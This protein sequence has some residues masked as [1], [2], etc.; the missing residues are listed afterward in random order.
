MEQSNNISDLSIKKVVLNVLYKTYCDVHQIVNFKTFYDNK[1]SLFFNYYF[2]V[3]D[4]FKN[5]CEDN[6]IKNKQYFNLFNIAFANPNYEPSMESLK[7]SEFGYYDTNDAISEK[8]E[9]EESFAYQDSSKRYEAKPEILIKNENNQ[10]VDV[11]DFLLGTENYSNMN[12]RRS[13]V[14]SKL[15]SNNMSKV[16][17]EKYGSNLTGNEPRKT[18]FTENVNTSN[19]YTTNNRSSILK[20]SQLPN[21]Q[22]Y[23]QA[24]ANTIKNNFHMSSIIPYNNLSDSTTFEAKV[25]AKIPLRNSNHLS[26]SKTATDRFST[27]YNNMHDYS[28]DTNKYEILYRESIIIDIKDKLVSLLF[29]LVDTKHWECQFDELYPSLIR[30]FELL[31]EFINGP[32]YLNQKLLLS[33]FT[34][35]D[36]NAIIDLIM[37]RKYCFEC[38]SYQL[39]ISAVTFLIAL[40]EGSPKEIVEYLARKIEPS[41]IF[42]Q[43]I[44]LT[45][46]LYIRTKYKKEEDEAAFLSQ[47]PEDEPQHTKERCSWKKKHYNEKF[48]NVGDDTHNICKSDICS[49]VHTPQVHT[50]SNFGDFSLFLNVKKSTIIRKEVNHTDKCHDKSTAPTNIDLNQTKR[51]NYLHQVSIGPDQSF[52]EVESKRLALGNSF[53]K[54]DYNI[55]ETPH[56]KLRHFLKHDFK[57]EDDVLLFNHYLQCDFFANHEVFE[58]IMKIFIL[59]KNLESS[60]T[61][62]SFMSNKMLLLRRFFSTEKKVKNFFSMNALI[63]KKKEKYN[64]RPE[65]IVV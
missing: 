40:I 64:T 50:Q 16:Y 48:F 12:S 17:A 44:S 42:K 39:Q 32:C 65:E 59:I 35:T 46:D 57:I 14:R 1:W 3:S 41:V 54:E 61:Y 27:K 31:T 55:F 2:N 4:I 30:Q 28:N 34:D 13:T 25:Q 36:I 60:F 9:L 62:S 43:M 24:I 47:I 8:T 20:K 22:N 21:E 37:K 18:V 23:D 49:D 5:L 56:Q 6:N 19:M 58:F 33:S 26:N 38:L 29:R 7:S 51:E 52:T 45:K 11:R 53:L 63:K 15:S 10:G